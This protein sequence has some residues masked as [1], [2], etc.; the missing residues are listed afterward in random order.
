MLMVQKSGV[1]FGN[2][3]SENERM[4]LLQ[5][6]HLKRKIIWTKPPWLWIQNLNFPGCIAWNTVNNR[7]STLYQLVCRISEASLFG[8]EKVHMIW[9]TID[10]R[11]CFWDNP[12]GQKPGWRAKG[13]SGEFWA[14]FWHKTWVKWPVCRAWKWHIIWCK[15]FM[16]IHV[17][18]ILWSP[19]MIWGPWKKGAL[20]V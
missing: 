11:F 10:F 17:N 2:Y 9:F 6:D 14:E 19:Q 8:G 18:Q 3:P 20:V 4:S 13:Q 12:I 15:T 5:R 7:I 16:G 1:P